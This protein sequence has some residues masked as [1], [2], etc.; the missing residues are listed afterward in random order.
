MRHGNKTFISC[1]KVSVFSKGTIAKETSLDKS[2]HFPTVEVL[3]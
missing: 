3:L 2:S 1:T